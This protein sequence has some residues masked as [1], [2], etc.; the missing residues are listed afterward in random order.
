MV[1][2]KG[3]KYLKNR[4]EQKRNSVKT[5]YEYYEMKNRIK[6]FQISTRQN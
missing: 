5:R 3:M 1:E 6:D 4:L 2:Y